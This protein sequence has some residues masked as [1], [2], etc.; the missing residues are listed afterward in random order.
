MG[1]TRKNEKKQTRD[2]VL[3]RKYGIGEK[4]Y[5]I[6]LEM[7]DFACVICRLPEDEAP[8]KRLC[9]D[10]NHTTNEIRGLL[11]QNCNF[12]LGCAKENQTTLLK[13]IQY[14]KGNLRYS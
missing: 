9:V 14:L 11:C 4:E 13:A 3:I 6:L 2:E 12:L 7:Q 8:R 5:R 10:H 1:K